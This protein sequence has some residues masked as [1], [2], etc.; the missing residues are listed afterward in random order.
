MVDQSLFLMIDTL[1]RRQKETNSL[2]AILPCKMVKNFQDWENFPWSYS[3]SIL[4]HKPILLQP[5][6][7]H[8]PMLILVLEC[9]ARMPGLP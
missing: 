3:D 9:S 8:F 1:S 5:E 4:L 2:F 6:H 7:I